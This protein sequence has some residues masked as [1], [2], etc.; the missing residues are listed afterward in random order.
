MKKTLRNLFVVLLTVGAF[1]LFSVSK[2]SAQAAQNF[3]LI[4]QT[5]VEI[6]ALYVTPSGAK[7]WG[8]DILGADTL[9]DG[10]A[11]DIS[12]SRRE[13]AKYW[14]LRIEDEYGKYL[15][16]TNLNLPA[17]ATITLYYKN[18]KT[19]AYFTQKD[20][21]LEGIWVGY[22]A[23]GSLSPYKWAISQDGKNITITDAKSG[24]AKSRGSVN[25]DKVYASDFATKNGTVTPDGLEIHWS[26]GVVWV[27]Q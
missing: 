16:W 14:D 10:S 11:L 1:S 18:G 15:V 21:N 2:V 6:Y 5:G 8:E 3:R 25:G 27:R 17:L 12:F 20:W 24:R 23:D 26:D 9:D 4:N 13:T 19:T 7:D 22:Y